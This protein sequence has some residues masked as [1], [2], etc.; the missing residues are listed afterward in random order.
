M[1]LGVPCVSADVGGVT[2]LMTHGKEGYV[3]QSTASYM[4]AHYIQ[5][6]FAME[7]AAAGLGA[8]AREHASHTHDPEK[9]LQDLL[10]IYRALA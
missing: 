10:N 1:L 2:D 8:A 9:N 3:Y 6:I 4:L 5:Q 7:D